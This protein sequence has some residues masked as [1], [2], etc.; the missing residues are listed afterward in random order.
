MATVTKSIGA[1]GKD[2]TTIVLWEADL[3]NGTPYDAGDIAVGECYNEVYDEVVD[4]DGGG[5]LRLNSIILSVA[6]GERHD[7]TA[8]T[9]AR[10]VRSG[11]S[12]DIINVTLLSVPKTVKW[13]EINAG[14]N[15]VGMSVVNVGALGG[16]Q[17]LVGNLLVHDAL[18][19]GN[20][21]PTGISFD[22]VDV[23]I[24]N[25][26]VYDIASNYSGTVTSGIRSLG[27]GTRV[28]RAFN[29]TIHNI[30]HDHVSTGTAYCVE[31]A[32]DTE[33]TIQNIIATDPSGPTTATCYKQSSPSNAIV[34]HNLSSDAT[35]SGTGSLINKASANQFVST[36]GGSEDLHLKA[37]ADAIDAGVDLV[38][39]PTG[40][41]IDINGRD[42][43]ALGDIWDMGAHEF[44][45]VGGGVAPTSTI[46]GSL[47]GPFAG[48][49]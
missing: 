21:S 30:H 19:V 44:V 39:T 45:A 33:I 46:Y 14:G 27:T 48:P 18:N 4:L 2:Y 11:S 23:D 13:I 20:L 47:W 8:G 41:N 34:D 25:C 38:T 26:I 24:F 35:A 10:I 1:S 7:G 12:T 3:D 40:V 29:I 15:A 5:T 17:G 31:F 43:D 28:R 16:V 6:S 37:G 49:I 32:D 22:S 36:V 42:R 9:G